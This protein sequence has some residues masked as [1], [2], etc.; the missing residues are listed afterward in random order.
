MANITLEEAK[1][2]VAAVQKR[3]ADVNKPMTVCVV[4]TTGFP[5]LIERMDGAR[6]LQV[7]IATA[8]AYTAAIM[9]RPGTMLKRWAESDPTFFGQVSRMGHKPVVAAHGALPL[10]RR[11]EL[12]GGV[13]VSGGTGEED[14]QVGLAALQDIGYELEF[15]AFNQIRH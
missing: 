1:A 14:E 2:V 15:S 10:K 3:A 12:I 4:D 7:E 11:G 8:K 13:G 5:V 9:Q 6:P